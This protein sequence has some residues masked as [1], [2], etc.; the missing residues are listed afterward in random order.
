MRWKLFQAAVFIS[1]YGSLVNLSQNYGER[2]ITGYA[3]ALLALLV[4]YF[5]T[6]IVNAALR[7]AKKRKPA[8]VR[9]RVEPHFD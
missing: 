3:P 5:S 6:L 7:V 8:S 9:E 1:V 4:T 2:E